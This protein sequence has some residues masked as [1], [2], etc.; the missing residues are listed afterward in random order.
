MT[1][2]RAASRAERIQQ[3][4]V[5]ARRFSLGHRPRLQAAS[6]VAHARRERGRDAES[7]LAAASKG[8]RLRNNAT[9]RYRAGPP[10][11][12]FVHSRCFGARVMFAGAHSTLLH[13]LPHCKAKRKTGWKMHRQKGHLSKIEQE[14]DCE[15]QAASPATLSVRLPALPPSCVGLSVRNGAAHHRDEAARD[16]LLTLRRSENLRAIAY[17]R[18]SRLARSRLSKLSVGQRRCG[19]CHSRGMYETRGAREESA[20]SKPTACLSTSRGSPFGSTCVSSGCISRFSFPG[21]IFVA[22]S[23]ACD[24][25][26]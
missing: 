8:A 15:V 22:T 23:C 24:D 14:A 18:C 19:A 13:S 12:T 7:R 16:E 4:A 26:I 1:A 5:H 20:P 11:S 9:G 21:R 3:S 2:A 17:R 25:R 10:A 6:R